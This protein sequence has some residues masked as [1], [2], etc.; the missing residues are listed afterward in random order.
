MIEIVNLPFKLFAAFLEMCD[1]LFN[2]AVQLFF[3]NIGEANDA[4][5]IRSLG[6]VSHEAAEVFALEI[7]HIQLASIPDVFSDHGFNRSL[8]LHN[9]PSSGAVGVAENVRQT[10]TRRNPENES[11]TRAPHRRLQRL[12]RINGW[13]IVKSRIPRM[14]E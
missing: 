1:L 3:F 6:R 4:S 13:L 11:K 9:D 8:V 5:E 14:N 2:Y 12:V 10:K 7:W